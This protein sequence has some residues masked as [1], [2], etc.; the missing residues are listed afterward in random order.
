MKSEIVTFSALLLILIGVLLD[1][2]CIAPRA[3]RP[4]L[5][6]VVT[7]LG[8]LMLSGFGYVACKSFIGLP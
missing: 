1:E 6:S 7:V 8:V 4:L 2:L 3:A 5:R